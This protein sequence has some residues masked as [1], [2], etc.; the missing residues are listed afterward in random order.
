MQC[1][2]RHC[3]DRTIVSVL[4][5]GTLDPEFRCRVVPE[6]FSCRSNQRRLGGENSCIRGDIEQKSR[7][8][9]GEIWKSEKRRGEVS[10]PRAP[11]PQFS[12]LVQPC[13]PDGWPIGHHYVF[14]SLLVNNL[15]T[16]VDRHPS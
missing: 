3:Q 9:E 13:S 10:Q 4:K 11:V 12:F 5:I 14:K 2:N 15:D 8:N 1:L 6:R 7:C 16:L